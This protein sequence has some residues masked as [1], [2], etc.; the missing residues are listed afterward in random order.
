M[1]K[2]HQRVKTQN[3]NNAYV[4]NNKYTLIDLIHAVRNRLGLNVISR[5]AWTHHRSRHHCFR[6]Q[7]LAKELRSSVAKIYP[8]QCDLTDES[9]VLKTFKWIETTIGQGVSVMINNAGTLMRTRLL[10]TCYTILRYILC[11][12]GASRNLDNEIA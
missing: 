5:N 4:T 12:L 2:K 8:V 9:N 6:A 3:R 11:Y 10:S 1:Q 7:E